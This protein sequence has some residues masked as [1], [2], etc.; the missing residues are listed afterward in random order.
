[1]LLFCSSKPFGFF[2]RSRYCRRRLCLISAILLSSKNLPTMV[3]WRRTSPLYSLDRRLNVVRKQFF[4]TVISVR[5]TVK[6]R[7]RF[8]ANQLS[9]PTQVCFPAQFSR[10]WL[11]Q[12]VFLFKFW[13]VHQE[14]CC[15]LWLAN[16]TTLVWLLRNCKLQVPLCVSLHDISVQ[17]FQYIRYT[18]YPRLTWLGSIGRTRALDFKVWKIGTLKPVFKCSRVPDRT[19]V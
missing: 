14:N 6:L 8:S 10:A 5:L 16:T 11:Q 3:T 9:N 4:S 17:G 1:M 19:D 12:H 15:A 13:L 18:S 2:C 7:A